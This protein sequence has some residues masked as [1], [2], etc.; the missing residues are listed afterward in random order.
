MQI[1]QRTTFIHADDF[2]ITPGQAKAILSL[3]SS[4]GGSGALNSVSIFANSPAFY[5]AASLA[6]PYVRHGVLRVCLHLNL[7]EGPSVADPKRIPL[8]VNER[9]MFDNN[10]MG[11]FKLGIT[12]N[13]EAFYQLVLE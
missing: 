9:G 3:S 12:N 2:G 11:L 1:E 5:E 6:Q 7:V 13:G 8:L 10:F 4:C